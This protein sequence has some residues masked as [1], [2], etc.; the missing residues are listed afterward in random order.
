MASYFIAPTS[1]YI[2]L[3]NAKFQNVGHCCYNFD[4]IVNRVN[5]DGIMLINLNDIISAKWVGNVL[6]NK[7]LSPSSQ[8]Q[9]PE[10]HIISSDETVNP[11]FNIQIV[12]SKLKEISNRNIELILYLDVSDQINYIYRTQPNDYLLLQIII[13]IGH[14]FAGITQ[15]FNKCLSQTQ[16]VSSESSVSSENQLSFSY[17]TCIQ[18]DGFQLRCNGINPFI[19]SFITSSVNYI[20][21]NFDKNIYLTGLKHQINYN[22]M[23]HHTNSN[24]IAC[25]ANNYKFISMRHLYVLKTDK[26]P[27]NNEFNTYKHDAVILMKHIQDKKKEL[28]TVLKSVKTQAKQ[29]I[30]NI[31]DV[32]NT[33]SN[34]II[35]MNL[36]MEFDL[37]IYNGIQHI[38]ENLKYSP[39]SSEKKNS[40]QS[41]NPFAST[42]GSNSVKN[43]EDDNTGVT[44]EFKLISILDL[45]SNGTDINV[46]NSFFSS[47]MGIQ[48]KSVCVTYIPINIPN[49]NSL[50]NHILQN[51]SKNIAKD[52]YTLDTVI[53]KGVKGK[54]IFVLTGN[55]LT[56]DNFKKIIACITDKKQIGS[57]CNP[58]KSKYINFEI[59]PYLRCGMAYYNYMTIANTVALTTSETKESFYIK[60]ARHYA[61][62][63]KYF[64]KIRNNY[65]KKSTDS[66]EKNES[67]STNCCTCCKCLSRFGTEYHEYKYIPYLED[68]VIDILDLTNDIWIPRI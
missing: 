55:N 42:F 36:D 49:V 23:A 34:I 66:T 63:N 39:P 56:F 37:Q 50:P 32:N 21:K 7:S 16:S 28:I 10:W 12:A 43:I 14:I 20:G 62:F 44:V 13:N 64:T 53:S 61:R 52:I 68:K 19:K 47:N 4:N 40:S 3:N 11:D 22:N 17:I 67:S 30:E 46:P 6:K 58:F 38:L 31:I 35:G 57:N 59:N 41:L 65:E 51:I 26:L 2:K 25:L 5:I 1:K 18:K 48:K 27:L 8:I 24:I 29:T 9:L 15:E 33:S 54:K 60:N 45:M